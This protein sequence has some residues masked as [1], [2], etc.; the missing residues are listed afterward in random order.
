MARPKQIDDEQLLDSLR[1]TFLEFGAGASTQE[2]ARRAGVSEGTLFKRFATKKKIFQAAMRL[3]DMEERVWYIQMLDRAGQ[4][5]LEKHLT[6]LAIG[7]RAFFDEVMPLWSVISAGGKLNA[8]EISTLIGDNETPPPVITI[9]RFAT[10]FA[11]EMALGRMRKSD[12]VA[13]ARFFIGGLNHEFHMRTFFP[14]YDFGDKD[15]SCRVLIRAFLA[16]VLVESD[17]RSSQP[18]PATSGPT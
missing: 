18:A 1:E 3:P 13:L 9:E 2:L 12:P 7:L 14:A 11:K 5:S 15:E 17:A 16:L 8:S 10:L 4:G 6:E